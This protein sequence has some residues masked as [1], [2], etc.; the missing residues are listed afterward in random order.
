M[1]QGSVRRIRWRYDQGDVLPNKL[2]TPSHFWKFRRIIHALEIWKQKVDLLGQ[3][4]AYLEVVTK[5][6]LRT[7]AL[8]NTKR[9]PSESLDLFDSIYGQLLVCSHAIQ[10]STM[11]T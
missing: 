4:E 3:D 1:D 11:R 7:R 6:R 9:F 10:A 8:D 5:T 2:V